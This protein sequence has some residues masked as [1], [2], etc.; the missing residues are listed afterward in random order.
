MIPKVIIIF[1]FTGLTGT[2]LAGTGVSA[3]VKGPTE[4]GTWGNR[5]GHVNHK[6]IS[7]SATM[8]TGATVFKFRHWVDADESHAPKV[9]PLEGMIGLL[10][11]ATQNW[12]ANGFLR[13]YVNGTQVGETPVKSVRVTEEGS[14]GAV[15]FEWERKEGIWRVTFLAFPY[16]KSLFCS[17]RYFPPAKSADWQIVLVNFPAGATRDGERAVTTAGRTVK[18][19]NK[20]DL[21][22]SGEW[23]AVYYDNVHEAGTPRSEGPSALV[24][25]PEDV[26][27]CKIDIGT[28][29][30]TTTIQPRGNE[31]RMIFWD[32]FFGR[33][34]AQAVDYMKETG[35]D[36]LKKL[37][38]TRFSNSA[39]FSEEWKT[40]QNE[41]E[42]FLAELG[43][44]LKESA[45]AAKL[46]SKLTELTGRF[47]KNREKPD[48]ESEF[49]HFLEAQ[50]KLLLELQSKALFE[51]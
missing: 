45:E 12:Y 1:C 20:I 27:S 39:I 21:S 42:K 28:Y 34:N 37:R 9:L 19:E 44:P 32:F 22:A 4:A 8:K 2:V 13:L 17:V 24:F 36:Q 40:R 43:N 3:N 16:G 5:S 6:K 49:I 33:K 48:D 35:S 41:I 15:V 50:K 23:W 7:Y 18:Q 10:G 47:M 38:Q 46:K 26:K 25:V 30:V 29:Q 51:K 14:R 31:V 11:A